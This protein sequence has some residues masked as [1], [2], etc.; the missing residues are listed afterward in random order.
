MIE[1]KEI[2][3]NLYHPGIAADR[4]F[5]T[6]WQDPTLLTVMLKLGRGLDLGVGNVNRALKRAEWVF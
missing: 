6:A 1:I 3:K 2:I 4:R 5:S